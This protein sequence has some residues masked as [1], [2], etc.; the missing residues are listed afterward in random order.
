MIN[1]DRI[2]VAT[3]WIYSGVK[4]FY[5]AFCNE[6]S[7]FREYTTFFDI[8]GL[9]KFIK[10]FLLFHHPEIYEGYRDQDARIRI[11]REVKNKKWGHNF[12]TMVEETASFIGKRKVDQILSTSFDGFKGRE[13]IKVIEKGYIESRYPIA[14]P[15]YRMHPIKNTRLFRDPLQSTGLDKF[16]YRLCQEMLLSLKETADLSDLKGHVERL[17]DNKDTGRRFTDLFF[18]PDI[19]KYF[20]TGHK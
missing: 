4:D 7:K 6:D 1:M 19:K 17:L 13:F 3:I 20:S 2:Q 9:E 12:K 14:N 8:Q 16:A 18:E 5:F 10:G 11:E 15:V